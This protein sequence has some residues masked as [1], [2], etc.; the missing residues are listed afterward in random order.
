KIVASARPRMVN[1]LTIPT[2]NSSAPRMP[3]PVRCPGP[4]KYAIVTGTIGKTHGV[5]SER[6]PV[7]PASQRKPELT[8]FRKYE[9][10]RAAY[11]CAAAGRLS[12]CKPDSAHQ[13]GIGGF[14]SA[15]GRELRPVR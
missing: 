7:L 1:V 15:P 14:H 2:P 5:R 6:S 13:S 4:E 3:E 12:R 11:R 8:I 10:P 9:V